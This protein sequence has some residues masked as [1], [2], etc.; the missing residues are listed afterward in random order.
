MGAI[1]AIEV[2]RLLG[3]LTGHET[4]ITDAWLFSAKAALKEKEEGM[5]R[6]NVMTGGEDDGWWIRES[7]YLAEIAK[8][9]RGKG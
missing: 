9:E 5:I 2:L 4:S 8:R 1:E 3:K 7:H 6:R